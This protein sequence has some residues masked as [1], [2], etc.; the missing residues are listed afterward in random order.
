MLI[1]LNPVTLP[2]SAYH[3]LSSTINNQIYRLFIGGI[4]S[5]NTNFTER[6]LVIILDGN[7][8]FASVYEY[9]RTQSLFDPAIVDPIVVGIGYPTDDVNTLLHNRQRDMAPLPGSIDKVDQFLS[10]ICQ[11]VLSFLKT[12]LGLA[13]N[14]EILAGHSWG[15]AFPLYA[16]GSINPVFDGYLA[17]S[18]SIYGT[19]I[20][21]MD[22]HIQKLSLT[23]N[24]KLFTSLGSDEGEQFLDISETFP[25]LVKAL[26]QYAPDNLNY[27][28]FIFEEENHSSVTHAALAKGLRYLL[29]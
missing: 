29:D 20:E 7:W 28:S 16:M 22:D 2:D 4:R 18:P 12:E 1:R 10:F 19:V 5:N 6:P 26:E 15:G 23:K 27:Q 11:D 3:D 8:L 9:L 24:T 17:S 21:K 25:L 14:K 13:F